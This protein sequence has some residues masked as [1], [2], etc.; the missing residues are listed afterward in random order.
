[1]GA[2]TSLR[3]DAGT[4][5]AREGGLPRPFLRLEPR[6]LALDRRQ[7]PLPLRQ[8]ALDRGTVRA[9]RR[10]HPRLLRARVLEDAGATL[11]LMSKR[12]DLLEDPGV[13]IG[14]AV[15]S[16]KAVQEVI[17]VLRP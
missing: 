4:G 7:K 2:D 5:R 8:L 17:E 1:V 13:L 14:N 6:D 15:H 11:H 16:I 10:N 12:A 9:L 3:C